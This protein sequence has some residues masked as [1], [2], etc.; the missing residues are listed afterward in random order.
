M[1]WRNTGLRAFTLV[2]LLTV[3]AVITLLVALLLPSLRQARELSNR[4]RCQ[5]NMKVI[6]GAVV[7]YATDYK[8]F[9]PCGL[10]P[11]VS[12][13]SGL[14]YG[15]P[16]V[17]WFE[18]PMLG[19]YMGCDIPHSA[20][21]PPK[22]TPV[23]CPS[24]AC[25]AVGVNADGTPTAPNPEKSWIGW[26]WNNVPYPGYTPPGSPMHRV[27]YRGCKFEEI[28]N[29]P[30]QVPIYCDARGGSI[31]M[32][33]CELQRLLNPGV[34]SAGDHRHNGGIDYLFADNHAQYIANP[35]KA[36]YDGFF[37]TP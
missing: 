9:P 3:I 17:W 7:A 16:Y 6:G 30:A 34:F 35:D 25:S 32:Y 28:R 14:T 22:G 37:L 31:V 10:A 1:T 18:K 24:A 2:E 27:Y 26:M 36:Y 20:S 19:Q 12:G 13:S 5:A 33:L 15:S 23:K 4:M 8:A 11:I 21:L 29:P